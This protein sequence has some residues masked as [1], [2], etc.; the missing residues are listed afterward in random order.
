M[1]KSRKAQKRVEIY[2]TTLTPDGHG[3]NTSTLNLV[4]T[5]WCQIKDLSAKPFQNENGIT[6]FNDTYQFIF[7][8]DPNLILDPKTNVLKYNG[9]SYRI[10]SVKNFGF[11]HVQQTVI[12]KQILGYE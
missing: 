2:L 9:L 12:A 3:G 4:S 7:R 8:Y 1:F 6:D 10:L 5:R 11:S